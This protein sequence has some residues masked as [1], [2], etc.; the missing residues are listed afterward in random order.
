M[1]F[2][3]SWWLYLLIGL[4]FAYVLL[5][6]TYFLIKARK[7]AIELGISKQDINKTITST[8]VFSIAPSIAILIGLIALTK[9]FG[10]LLSAM[11]LSTLGAVTYELPA[12]LSVIEG[13]FNMNIGDVLT[14]QIVITALW[15]MTLG[16]IPPKIIIPLFFRKMSDKMD[17]IKEKDQSWN[18]IM[19]DALF[20]GMIVAF[21]GYVIAPRVDSITNQSYISVL[22]ILVLLSSAVILIV[23]GI[24]INK[25]K[26]EW[27][28]NYALPVSMV[29]AMGLAI[30]FAYW[31]IR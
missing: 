2:L 9:V 12:A 28:R 3:Y 13:V 8:I 25:F 27:L 7:Q 26:A 15:V 16:C 31:G 30:L 21:V 23:I 1:D 19:M 29:G 22:A 24:I 14:P 20:I 4:V 5:Q 17:Q 18:K 11:R 6:S 10:P